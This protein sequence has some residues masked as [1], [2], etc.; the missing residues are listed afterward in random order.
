LIEENRLLFEQNTWA[1]S[2]QKIDVGLGPCLGREDLVCSIS[3]EPGHPGIG[4]AQVSEV[5]TVRGTDLN[6]RRFLTAANP[7]QAE[8]ALVDVAFRMHETRVIRAGRDARLAAGAH[9]VIHEDHALVGDVTGPGGT[10]IH[11]G[12][13]GAVVAALGTV[14]GGEVRELAM[15]LLH[16]PV[17]AESIGDVVLG[18]AG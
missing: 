15:D 5:Q 7:V 8:R 4:V 18:L 6:A 17:A 16:H 12:R 10:G 11:A 14:L 9:V 3:K 2:F 13:P 1:F